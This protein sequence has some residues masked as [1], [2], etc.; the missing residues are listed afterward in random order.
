MRRQMKGIWPFA[1]ITLAKVATGLLGVFF[2][3]ST[4]VVYKFYEHVPADLVD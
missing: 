4:V 2:I 1:Y 3:W